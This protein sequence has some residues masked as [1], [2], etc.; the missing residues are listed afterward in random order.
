MGWDAVV[1]A[2]VV[3]CVGYVAG[4]VTAALLH[5]SGDAAPDD[6]EA[7]LREGAALRRGREGG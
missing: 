3:G 5:F 1:V 6:V 4:F 7:A 2:A